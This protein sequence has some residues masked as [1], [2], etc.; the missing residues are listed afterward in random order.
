MWNESE[1]DIQKKTTVREVCLKNTIQ[2]S[3]NSQLSW[4][5][6]LFNQISYVVAY[7]RWEVID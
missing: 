4:K 1:S 5:I 7:S 2:K 6:Q 3:L